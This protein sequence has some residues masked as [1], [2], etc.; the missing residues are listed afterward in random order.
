MHGTVHLFDSLPEVE[1]APEA[2]L[3]RA[4]APVRAVPLVGVIRN[5]RSHRNAEALPEFSGRA[6]LMVE[7]PAKRGELPA[8]LAR[9][10]E[11]RID[12]LVVDGGDGTVR[13]VLTC[14]SGVFG[15]SWPPLIV[16]PNGKTNALATD[17]GLGAEWNLTTALASAE[18]GKFLQRRPLVIARRDNPDA[19][20][21]GFVFGAGVFTASVSLGQDA[22]RH[23]AFNS[24]A[25]LVTTL[26]TFMQAL[27]GRAGNV[28]RRGT[29]IRLYAE[30]GQEF[31]HSGIGRR[32][33]RYF[34]FASTLERFSAGLWPFSD[35]R[36]PLRMAVLD[37][38][39]MGLLLR[40]P[41]ILNG[42]RASAKMRRLGY[43][44]FGFER[45][46]LDIADNFILDGEAFPAGQYTL[47][48]GPKLRFVIP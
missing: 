2:A 8:I 46:G 28:W 38:S 34:L 19:R 11:K 20:V 16:L 33:E 22:H 39:R 26:W 47:S 10:A 7:L 45:C 14:G 5:R 25:V 35:V 21:Q 24:M 23:G 30:D 44:A 41:L 32:D 15:E 43:H 48:L 36:T 6:T 1:R 17:L 18:E 4:A 42:R 31:P 27:F 3:R 37:N 29:P 9:F 12:Y 13:D 40:L